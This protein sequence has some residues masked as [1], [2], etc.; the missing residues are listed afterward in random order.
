MPSSAAT[1]AIDFPLVRTSSTASRLNSAE[2]FRRVRCAPCCCSSD[3]WTILSIEVSSCTGEVQLD[4][5]PETLRNWTRQAEID[6]GERAGTSSAEHEE[7]KR[8]RA[9]NA[10]LRRANEILRKAS[11]YFASA[12]LDRPRR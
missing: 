9:E 1:S 10:E 3:M 8:L 5:N 11:A 6:D 2:N 12:E 7:N 4:I